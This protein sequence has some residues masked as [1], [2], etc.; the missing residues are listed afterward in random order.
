ML[1]HGRGPHPDGVAHIC[2]AAGAQDCLW[3]CC[4]GEDAADRGFQLLYFISHDL[5]LTTSIEFYISKLLRQLLPR[6]RVLERDGGNPKIIYRPQSSGSEWEGWECSP[7]IDQKEL[8]LWLGKQGRSKTGEGMSLTTLSTRRTRSESGPPKPTDA[9]FQFV[10]IIE[11]NTWNDAPRD[12]LQVM[13][14]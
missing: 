11:F 8:D 13:K 1:R 3:L 7:R 9:Q 4:A 10:N 6:A 14:I 12:Y 5:K 2:R